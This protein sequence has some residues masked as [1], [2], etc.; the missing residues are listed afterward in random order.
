MKKTNLHF[1]KSKRILLAIALANTCVCGE[2]FAIN[3]DTPGLSF[4]TGFPES[5][6]DDQLGVWKRYYGFFGA[7]DFEATQIVNK[8]SNH[9]CYAKRNVGGEGDEDNDGWV[10]YDVDEKFNILDGLTIKNF[11]NKNGNLVFTI[12]ENIT[13]DKYW[14]DDN[15]SLHPIND[16]SYPK[17]LIFTGNEPKG[18]FEIITERKLDPSVKNACAGSVPFYT[19]P[20]KVEE[21]QNVVRIGST[22]DT[23]ISYSSFESEGY[24]RRAMAERMVYSFVVTENST[25][26]TCQYA[27]FL[28]DSPNL[29]HQSRS[30]AVGQHPSAFVSVTLKK[31]GSGK[32][33]KPGCGEY[34][35]CT[36][37]GQMF[38][39]D[40][41]GS[42]LKY[43]SVND[44]CYKDW[45]T[46][47]FDL[48]ENIG[49][50]LDIEVW[51]HDC[52]VEIPVCTNCNRAKA[53]TNYLFEDG[54]PYMSCNDVAWRNTD[55]TYDGYA[56]YVNLPGGGC[57]KDRVQAKIVPMAGGH[58]AYC[59]FTANTKRLEMMVDNNSSDDFV[60]ITAPAGLPHYAWSNSKG[61]SLPA[62]IGMDNVMKLKRSDIQEGVD[63]FC[64]M[65]AGNNDCSEIIG[66]VRL[67]ADDLKVV[68][69][70][71]ENFYCYPNPV[72][73]VLFV[74]G[75]NNS[76]Y[77]LFDMRGEL[78]SNGVMAGAKIDLSSLPSGGYWLKI[79]KEDG[80]AE[81]VKLLKE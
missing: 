19:M 8:I 54:V 81:Y 76:P 26:L 13:Y 22:G 41:A 42:C 52:L 25:L 1:V 12:G 45:S 40:I 61:D 49:D 35:L 24:Y 21:G 59:Y 4:E 71:G 64:S 44:V 50:T 23:E 60:T 75:Y 32:I 56:V 30:H 37:N 79:D 9:K 77:S 65:T 53:S 7:E 3:E 67:D 36:S 10:R 57:G 6:T 29:S 47:V 14:L 62:Y 20:D 72:N 28:E 17:T 51:V 70:M 16:E 68:D 39:Q 55:E 69:E 11:Y 34:E 33:I 48:R 46:S 66:S 31:R 5:F 15:G 74:K 27:S 18:S 73:D 63:Y 2:I 58:R 38:F 80:S 43:A 78:I